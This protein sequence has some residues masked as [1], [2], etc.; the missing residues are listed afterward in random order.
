MG[1]SEPLILT[2][3]RNGFM[4]GDELTPEFIKGLRSR[5]KREL[6]HQMNRR[7]D[8]KQIE[9]DPED[10]KLYGEY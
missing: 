2:E 3:D 7:T 10:A 4:K 8:F 9:S 6:A 5:R 1:E